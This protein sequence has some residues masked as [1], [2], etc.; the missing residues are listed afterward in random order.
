[1][2][3]LP[4]REGMTP[5][6][7][8]LRPAAGEAKAGIVAAA[9]MI[10]VLMGGAL[11]LL[12][13]A[14]RGVPTTSPAAGPQLVMLRAKALP[15]TEFAALLSALPRHVV[16]AV[17]EAYYEYVTAGDY[18]ETL[19]LLAAADIVPV[20]DPETSRKLILDTNHDDVKLVII[21]S[22]DVPTYVGYGDKPLAK[23]FGGDAAKKAIPAVWDMTYWEDWFDEMAR[24]RF[25]VLAIWNSHP[26]PALLDMEE[27]AQDVQG[28]DGYGKKMSPAEKVAFWQKVMQRAADR[29]IAIYFF[30]WNMCPNGAARPAAVRH[31][32]VPA[33]RWTKVHARERRR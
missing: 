20:D 7:N 12:H 2:N 18:P 24:A 19:P 15:L 32:V 33:S 8:P 10:L 14:Y 3:F 21:R 28:F 30:T 16:V 5:D 1:M 25:N 29:G 4:P 13:R 27:A 9:A 6:V 23:A 31:D 17:D 22:S 11:V 26:F